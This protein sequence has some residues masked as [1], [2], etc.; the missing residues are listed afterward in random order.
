MP[1]PIFMLV[2]IPA[3]LVAEPVGV[4]FDP[5]V[6][7]SK[8]AAGDISAALAS[9]CYFADMKDIALLDSSYPGKKVV[10]TLASNTKV[11]KLLAAQGGKVPARLGEQAYA[12]RT[13]QTRDKSFWV[14]GGDSNGAMYGGLEIAAE[15]HRRGFAG[16]RDTESSPFVLRRGIKANLPLDKRSPTYFGMGAGSGFRGTA[17]Q[18]AIPHVW[19]MNYWKEWFDEM[20]RSRFNVLTIWNCHP[21]PALGLDM[22]ES[23]SDVQGYDGFLKP[24]T[25]GQ[26]S[27]FWREV[28][29]Y[30]KGRGFETYFVTWNIY[31]HGTDHEA[32]STSQATKD[33][34]RKA[35]RLMLETF[36]DLAGIGVS[37]G[38]NMPGMTTDAKIT[39]L[40]ETYGSGIA[41]FARAN[42]KRKVTFLHRWL[43]ADVNTVVKKFASALALPN[44]HLEMT[45]KYSMAHLYSSPDPRWIFI[46]DGVN[47]VDGLVTTG[48][49]TWLELR[50]DDFYFLSWGDP[51]FARDFVAG[52]SDIKRHVSGFMYGGDGWVST[53]D[54]TS[55]QGAFS[56]VLEAKRDWLSYR[57]WGRLTYNPKERDDVFLDE[58]AALYPGVDARVLFEAWA[59]ASR[60]VPLAAE[61]VM[62]SGEK[63]D[64]SF[65]WDWQW[66][67]ELCQRSG[68]LVNLATFIKA[69]PADGSALCGIRDTAN[70]SCAGKTQT[71]LWVAG[72]IEAAATSALQKISSLDA[73]GF[74]ELGLYQKN[75]SAQSFLSLY[76]AEKI[77]G[78]TYKAAD[79][80]EAARDAMERAY[81]HWKTYTTLMN[82]LHTGANMERTKSFK[83]WSVHDGAVLEEYVALGGTGAPKCSMESAEGA[84]RRPG[85]EHHP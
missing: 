11:S 46:K 57:I 50:N 82:E 66:W 35:V 67:P 39:W 59:A 60:G 44:V 36:P 14:L 52:F 1:C 69:R 12:L 34:T 16:T 23:F 32:T 68:G 31:A 85:R 30:G 72:T 18:K 28:M 62:G 47:A 78:A 41:D 9:Q 83:D 73:A 38:E 37:A 80:A 26:K 65:W 7:Q 49:K 56:G 13:T 24:M 74:A 15:I 33:Y 17:A 20:A 40:S 84:G 75:I 63:G 55:K 27:A 8:F 10:V 3:M 45:F 76:Y 22:P 43:D 21:F 70:A 71:S 29:A 19:D 61:L 51:Q 2:G 48:R 54:F 79:K 81:C 6:A 4:F 64:G 58:I 5:G 25:R 77:R 42:P 53:R